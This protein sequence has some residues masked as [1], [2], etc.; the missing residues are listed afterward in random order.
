[1]EIRYEDVGVVKVELVEE[2]GSSGRL[3]L[4]LR[5]VY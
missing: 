2:G 3:E 1:M 5:G 4:V